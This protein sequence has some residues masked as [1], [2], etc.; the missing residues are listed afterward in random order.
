M[1]KEGIKK[2]IGRMITDDEFKDSFFANREKTVNASGYDVSAQELE[3]LAN[4]RADDLGVQIT[5]VIGGSDKAWGLS[6]SR[7]TDKL[8][9]NEKILSANPIREGLKTPG[10][11]INR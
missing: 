9:N 1:S 10:K 2:L 6:V 7:V 4:L 5:E 11:T 8:I 3:A